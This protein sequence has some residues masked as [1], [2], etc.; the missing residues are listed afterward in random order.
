MTLLDK[1]LALNSAPYWHDKLKLNRNALHNARMRGHISPAIAGA[2]AEEIGEDPRKWIV[3][4]ALESERDSACKEQMLKRFTTWRKQ[5][6]IPEVAGKDKV[7]TILEYF[8][9]TLD[10][11]DAYENT[12]KEALQAML[13]AFPPETDEAPETKKPLQALGSQGVSWRKRR[14]SNP[15]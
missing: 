4:A 8:V 10:V 5:K 3:V 12:A 1:A 11:N 9:D 13:T 15:R 7:R 6:Q 2:L 14:D